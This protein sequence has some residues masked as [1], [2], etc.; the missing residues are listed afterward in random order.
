MTRRCSKWQNAISAAR[1]WHS[2]LRF[3]TPTDV[4]TEL[5]SPTSSASRLLLTVLLA[6][7]TSVPDAFVPTRLNVQS[8]QLQKAKTASETKLFSFLWWDGNGRRARVD[9]T[10]FRVDLHPSVACGYSSPQGEPFEGRA[11]GD[12]GPYSGMEVVGAFT[13]GPRTM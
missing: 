1:A 4:P 8:D 11:V 7:C 12:A 9:R 2:V 6:M 13:S 5:G 3:L 10:G